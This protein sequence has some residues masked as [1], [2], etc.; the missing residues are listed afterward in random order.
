VWQL[1]NELRVN[2]STLTARRPFSTDFK[3]RAQIARGSLFETTDAIR[4][5]RLRG[6]ISD[7]EAQKCIQLANRLT[8]AM[9]RFIDYLRRSGRTDSRRARRTD[10]RYSR[11]DTRQLIGPTS[12]SP[13]PTSV[14]FR[15][16]E[17]QGRTDQRQ[18]LG[19]TF[20]K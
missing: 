11:T 7:E 8:P 19:P 18:F 3:R 2:V 15:T 6:H 13:G 14:R 16:D 9:N 10:S 5:A 4:S 12:V 20:V 17:R 1:A